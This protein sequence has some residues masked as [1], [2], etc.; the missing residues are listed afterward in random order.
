MAESPEISVSSFPTSLHYSSLGCSVPQFGAVLLQFGP[1][2]AHLGN[3][4]GLSPA[5]EHPTVPAIPRLMDQHCC[6]DPGT[7]PLGWP[8]RLPNWFPWQP[9]FNCLIGLH[10][11]KTSASPFRVVGHCSGVPTA[12]PP[13]LRASLGSPAAP[14]VPPSSYALQANQ[15]N[16]CS[17]LHLH[18]QRLPRYLHSRMGHKLAANSMRDNINFSS[19]RPPSSPSL[20]VFSCCLL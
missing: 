8:H 14:P 20:R 11:N 19:L 5:L 17:S 2:V 10:G 6:H 18:R 3:S 13:C 9:V 1:P 4:V 16:Q 12:A 15:Y 7:S